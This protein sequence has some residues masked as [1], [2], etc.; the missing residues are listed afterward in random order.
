MK[1]DLELGI[2]PFLSVSASLSD[3]RAP[4]FSPPEA[5]SLEELNWLWKFILFCFPAN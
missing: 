4:F 5:D 1:L 3:I 2:L